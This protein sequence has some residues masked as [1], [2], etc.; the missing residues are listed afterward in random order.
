M[1]K[2]E[3]TYEMQHDGECIAEMDGIAYVDEV[4][5][6]GAIKIKCY[7]SKTKD[8]VFVTGFLRANIVAQLYERCI[9]EIN[10]AAKDA[11]FRITE[12][13]QEVRREFNEN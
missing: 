10:Q 1:S 12:R 7:G 5:E 13:E 2:F 4:G 8:Y 6:V 9:E 11:S 3:F